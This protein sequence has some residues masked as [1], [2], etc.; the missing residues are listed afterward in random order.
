MNEALMTPTQDA[1]TNPY[2][3]FRDGQ[4]LF[5]MVS[6]NGTV[7]ERLIS[8]EAVREAATG[9]PIDS[10]WLA[11]EVVRWGTGRMGDW[12]VAFIPPGRHQLE[13]TTG[14]PGV[15]ETLERVTAPLPGM[16]IF[17][18]ATKYWAWAVRSERLNPSDE[19]YR[20]PL[21]N[22]MQDAAICWGELKPPVASA[23]SILKSWQIFQTSTFNN[24]AANAKSKSHSDDVREL[25]KGLARAGDYAQYP[26]QDLVRQV[27]SGV[28]LDRV[29]R[30]FFESGE[31]P[32]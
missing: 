12:A 30:D 26:V 4:C 7:M 17:G 8:W 3:E 14:T 22:V 29:I 6:L 1:T 31:M 21:P 18:I 28:T 11:P 9:I 13:L 16:V 2:L 15:D 20:A 23:R 25:L 27:E 24:H 10:G 32:G 5:R 19:L